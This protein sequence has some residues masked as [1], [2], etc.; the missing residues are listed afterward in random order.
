M[1]CIVFTHMSVHMPT[2]MHNT[3]L[4]KWEHT[5]PY[6]RLYAHVYR[7]RASKPKMFWADGGTRPQ[8]R[9]N[10]TCVCTHARRHVPS[11]IQ[12][13]V[14]HVPRTIEK[15]SLSR[16][17]SVP[18]RLY[19]C[20]SHGIGNAHTHRIGTM[21]MKRW[22]DDG[23]NHVQSIMGGTVRLGIGHTFGYANLK[24]AVYADMH[25]NKW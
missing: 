13:S 24:M 2:H 4:C 21:L 5:Y 3:C 1:Q 9:G 14:G 16:S 17:K 10:I 20:A 7:T 22:R 18:A 12:A 19:T 23:T 6:S 8:T 11:Y 25:A 15:L